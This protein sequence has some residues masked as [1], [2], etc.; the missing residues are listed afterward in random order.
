[1]PM[2]P[3]PLAGGVYAA[4]KVAGY[5]AF[6]IGLNRVAKKTVSPIKFGLAKTA[7][8]LAGGIG[9]LFFIESMF[10]DSVN[11]DLALWLWAM[12]VRLLAWAVVIAFFYGFRERPWLMSAA[13]IAGTA[14]SYGLDW[15]MSFFYR[16]LPGMEA[17]FC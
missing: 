8:G 6:A 5:A 13:V 11:S 17:P 2:V 12:P 10:K 3:S 15:L 7:V 14:W 9:Y 16:L 4:V 1:M